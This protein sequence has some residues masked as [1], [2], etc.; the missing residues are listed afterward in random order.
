MPKRRAHERQNKDPV[1]PQSQ[2][3]AED[4]GASDAGPLAPS[5]PEGKKQAL[6]ACDTEDVPGKK[7]WPFIDVKPSDANTGTANTKQSSATALTVAQVPCGPC[8]SMPK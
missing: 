8:Q 2:S 7:V 6:D 1:A 3:L 5:V 4:L